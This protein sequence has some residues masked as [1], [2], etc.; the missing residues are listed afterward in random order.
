MAS[1][2]KSFAIT[3]LLGLNVIPQFAAAVTSSENEQLKKLSTQTASLT[4]QLASLQQELNSV[5]AKLQ[6]KNVTTNRYMR[7]APNKTASRNNSTVA[8]QTN[9]SSLSNSIAQDSAEE[10][11][12]LPFD[13]DVPGQAFVSTG[14]YV[15]VP[16]QYSGSELIIN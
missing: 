14:P 3:F 11:E 9:S 12:Y 8:P 5:K 1:L 4:Q 16:V 10:R 2:A 7:M 15:G 13:L 6:E